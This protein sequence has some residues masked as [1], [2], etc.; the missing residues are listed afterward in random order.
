[1]GKEYPLGYAYF[2]DRCHKAFEKNKNIQDPEVVAKLLGHGEFVV[3]EL[4]ALYSL[5]KYRTMKKRYYAEE[6]ADLIEK[7]KK[8]ED[9]PPGYQFT[10]KS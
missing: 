2:R 1:M 10:S 7:L 8:I 3:K 4:T 6:N 5:K 9:L